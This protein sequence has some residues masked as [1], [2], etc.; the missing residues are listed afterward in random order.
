M[1]N[2]AVEY[3][4]LAEQPA[5]AA[6]LVQ[7]SAEELILAETKYQYVAAL[8]NGLARLCVG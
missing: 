8:E 6:Q 2:E 5:V 1:L 3:A 4:L 7:G